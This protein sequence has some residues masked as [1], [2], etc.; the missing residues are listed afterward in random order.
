VSTRRAKNLTLMAIRH[1][2]VFGG[3]I[4]VLALAVSSPS[5]WRFWLV[6]FVVLFVLA[7]YLSVLVWLHGEARRVR[8]ERSKD[9]QRTSG[10]AGQA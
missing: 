4:L 10:K 2:V 1:A 7:P 5:H 8:S 9:G 3:I 6:L